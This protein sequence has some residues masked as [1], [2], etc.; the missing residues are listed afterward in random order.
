M[1]KRRWIGAAWGVSSMGEAFQ[2]PEAAS[3]LAEVASACEHGAFFEASSRRLGT[4]SRS[5]ASLRD[6]G[7][8]R[9]WLEVVVPWLAGL[10]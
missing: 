2:V 3:I 10:G 4:A 9:G 7:A 8:H 6:L 1:E 5:G